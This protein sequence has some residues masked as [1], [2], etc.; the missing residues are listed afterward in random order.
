MA[1]NCFYCD[2]PLNLENLEK[3]LPPK[4]MV[5]CNQTCAEAYRKKSEILSRW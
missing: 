4:S 2:R 5:F 1:R 3:I